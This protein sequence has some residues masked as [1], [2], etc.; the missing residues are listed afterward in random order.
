MEAV[1]A[2]VGKVSAIII[3][4]I[5]V[6]LFGAGLIVFFWGLI[7][8]LYALNVHGE[9]SAEGKKHMFW[10]LVG[11]FIMAAALA[12]IKLIANTINVSLPPGY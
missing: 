2:V 9:Q 4:P 1:Q 8:Y 10:G 6:L 12:I 11:M 5:L 7:Q 3:N